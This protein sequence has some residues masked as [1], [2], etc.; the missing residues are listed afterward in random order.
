MLKQVA[1]H[2]RAY[3]EL[4]ELRDEFLIVQIANQVNA[5][6]GFHINMKHLLTA[7]SCRGE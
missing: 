4:R 5:N 6:L 2:Y 1:A 7:H 3:F